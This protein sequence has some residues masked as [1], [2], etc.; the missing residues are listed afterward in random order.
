[1]INGIESTGWLAKVK[2]KYWFKFDIYAVKKYIQIFPDEFF[3]VLA[4]L[5]YQTTCIIYELVADDFSDS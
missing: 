5:S 2:Q 1:M 3:Y 4:Y